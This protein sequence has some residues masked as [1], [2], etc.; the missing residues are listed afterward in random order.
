MA[1]VPAPRHNPYIPGKVVREAQGMWIAVPLEEMRLYCSELN[2]GGWIGVKGEADQWYVYYQNDPNYLTLRVVRREDNWLLTLPVDGGP[3]HTLK[4]TYPAGL[5]DQVV[6]GL[7]ASIAANKEDAIWWDGQ[8][9]ST[10]LPESIPGSA[11]P[12]MYEGD[13]KSAQ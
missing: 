6:A 10:I 2:I 11:T 7:R 12:K 9:L 13:Q 5:H 8:Q 1:Q 4:D 3:T